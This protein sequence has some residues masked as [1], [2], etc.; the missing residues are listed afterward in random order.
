MTNEKITLAD[1]EN[2][3]KQNASLTFDEYQAI[4]EPAV[5]ILINDFARK[6]IERANENGQDLT[7]DEA[8][9]LAKNEIPA[10][11]VPEWMRNLRVLANISGAELV[12]FDNVTREIRFIREILEVVFEKEIDEYAAKV[13]R[14]TAEVKNE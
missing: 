2:T 9:E 6:A 12:G 13:A 7:W 14:R 11:F 3:V 4:K 10:S 8:V 5:N 1:V